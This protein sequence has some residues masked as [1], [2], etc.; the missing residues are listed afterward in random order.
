MSKKSII[1]TVHTRIDEILAARDAEITEAEKALDDA[2]AVMADAQKTAEYAIVAADL[3]VYS[4]ARADEEK[5]ARAVELYTARLERLND[6]AFVDPDEDARVTAEIIAYRKKLQDDATASIMSHLSKIE[7]IGREYFNA[8]DTANDLY[9]R[10]FTQ[11]SGSYDRNVLNDG[12]LRF[13]IRALATLYFYRDRLGV[14]QY[15]GTGS[16]WTK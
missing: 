8:M 1:E 6:K 3:E 7:E 14:S 11:I 15:T 16:F 4:G 13:A 12:E 10:W 2:K 9:D 5:A